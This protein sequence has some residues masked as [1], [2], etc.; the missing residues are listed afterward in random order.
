[1]TNSSNNVLP[2][3]CPPVACQKPCQVQTPHPSPVWR[4]WEARKPGKWDTVPAPALG[5]WDNTHPPPLAGL[6][7]PSCRVI[8]MGIE[9]LDG[10]DWPRVL[11]RMSRPTEYEPSQ[12][13]VCP[14]PPGGLCTM[15]VACLIY[16]SVDRGASSSFSYCGRRAKKHGTR[17]EGGRKE[18]VIS[19]S[20]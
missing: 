9:P 7:S 10:Y 13:P 4:A 12:P 5:R 11:S 1:M 18:E 17:W 19:L 16:L 2:S 14:D 15:Y 20:A 6:S 8:H 3:S